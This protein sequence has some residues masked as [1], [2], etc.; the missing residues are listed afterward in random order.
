MAVTAGRTGSMWPWSTP[1][2]PAKHLIQVT[3][4]QQ[5]DKTQWGQ[6]TG[7]PQFDSKEQTKQLELM[8]LTTLLLSFDLL[9]LVTHKPWHNQPLSDVR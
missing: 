8:I 6:P 3:E 2:P 4:L 7:S 9:I 1:V 5:L